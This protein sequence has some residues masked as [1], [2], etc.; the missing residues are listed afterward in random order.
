MIMTPWVDGWTG[1]LTVRMLWVATRCRP[2][3]PRV[4]NYK[5][6]K[7]HCCPVLQSQPAD[8]SQPLALRKYQLASVLVL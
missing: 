5:V 7:C 6:E 3:G 2:G 1:G 8:H 4:A